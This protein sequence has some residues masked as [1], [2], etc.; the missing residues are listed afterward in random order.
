MYLINAGYGD[1]RNML[2]SVKMR[3]AFIHELTHVWQM[4]H[5]FAVSSLIHLAAAIATGNPALIGIT[6][7]GFE[8]E[9]QL[10]E[11]WYAD[12]M[13]T[14]SPLYPYIV[15]HILAGAA[16]EWTPGSDMA[17]AA[18]GTKPPTLAMR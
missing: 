11:Q 9:A 2:S 4:K 18:G 10:V 17:G 1:Y 6:A 13:K 8:R 5:K 7:A 14:S 3:R 16:R 15:T 12:G